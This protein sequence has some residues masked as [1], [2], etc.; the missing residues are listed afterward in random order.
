MFINHLLNALTLFDTGSTT[1][2]VSPEYAR[3]AGLS[4]FSLNVPV[5]LQ[6][7]CVGS[8]S[9]INYGVTPHVTFGPVSGPWYFDLAN[10]DRYDVILGIPFMMHAGI[11]LDLTTREVRI[12]SSVFPALKVG[13]DPRMPRVKKPTPTKQSD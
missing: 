7:G 3:V 8:R 10:I 4:V 12:G 1:D 6:L 11:I 2:I 13:E 5:P 9:S